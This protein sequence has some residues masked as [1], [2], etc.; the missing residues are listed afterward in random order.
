MSVLQSIAPNMPEATSHFMNWSLKQSS[1]S[2]EI[3][4][5]SGS[6]IGSIKDCWKTTRSWSYDS[7]CLFKKFS[8]FLGALIKS[9]ENIIIDFHKFSILTRSELTNE[10]LKIIIIIF[11]NFVGILSSRSFPNFQKL[12][13]NGWFLYSDDPGI[14]KINVKIPRA[15]E[16]TKFL[17]LGKLSMVADFQRSQ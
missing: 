4:L 14:P 16:D 7:C 8:K 15:P 11:I 12:L 5:Y 3:S 13:C 10:Y 2:A 1:R 9:S 6:S 17:K